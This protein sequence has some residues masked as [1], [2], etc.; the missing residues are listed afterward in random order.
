LYLRDFGGDRPEVFVVGVDPRMITSGYLGDHELSLVAPFTSFWA[1]TRE[2]DRLLGSLGVTGRRWSLYFRVVAYRDDV[3]DLFFHP[4]RITEIWSSRPRPKSYESRKE[5]RK[6]GDLCDFRA[7]T[8]EECATNARDLLA[9]TGE[10]QWE[11]ALSICGYLAGEKAQ[12]AR[13]VALVPEQVAQEW[14]DLFSRLGRLYRPLIVLL[15]YHS[16]DR[17]ESAQGALEA[18]RTF[19]SSLVARSLVY[20]KDYADL[21]TGERECE[22]FL[23]PF[24]LNRKGAEALSRRV[25]QD[26]RELYPEMFSSSPD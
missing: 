1:H 15:P 10:A 12:T 3:A 4:S 7:A 13:N 21:F 22:F 2:I 16:L 17:R 20:T 14:Q 9:R 26:V 6:V 23:D 25:G 19:L 18:S 11:G 8:A 5:N 24:H